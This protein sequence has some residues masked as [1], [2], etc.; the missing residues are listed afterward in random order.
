MLRE[1]LGT[2]YDKYTVS[3]WIETNVQPYILKLN[4][5]SSILRSLANISAW[6]PRYGNLISK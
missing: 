2:V 3:E 1:T 6:G 5:T 4:H